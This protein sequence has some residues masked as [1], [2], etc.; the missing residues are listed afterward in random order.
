[1]KVIILFL[2]FFCTPFSPRSPPPPQSIPNWLPRISH[3][4]TWCMTFVRCTPSLPLT[5]LTP[6]RSSR[7]RR[8]RKI[9][10]QVLNSRVTSQV[11][12]FLNIKN[13]SSRTMANRLRRDIMAAPAAHIVSTMILFND[14]ETGS[15]TGAHC[16]ALIALSTRG[17]FVRY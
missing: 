9:K 2:V 12:L 8:R 10:H 11:P 15:K 13:K 6:P 3:S 7:R 1:V 5:L 16:G 17:R 14:N 4:P